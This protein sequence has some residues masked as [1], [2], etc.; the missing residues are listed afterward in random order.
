MKYTI[1]HKLLFQKIDNHFMCFDSE[2]SFILTLNS[3]AVEVFK[4]LKKG[5]GLEE[6]ARYLSDKY[7]ISKE[8]TIKDTQEIVAKFLKYKICH[9]TRSK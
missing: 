7:K 8:K 3:T 9:S 2:N 5:V 1:N 4:H 6:I